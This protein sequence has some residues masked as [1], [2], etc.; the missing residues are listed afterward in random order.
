[1]TN[2]NRLAEQLSRDVSF[3]RDLGVVDYS[4][5]LGI[6]PLV[7]SDP[8]AN[9]TDKRNR[10][11]SRRNESDVDQLEQD[12]EEARRAK[13]N[14]YA[15]FASAIKRSSLGFVGAS[16]S[17]SS[18]TPY[19]SSIEATAADSAPSTAPP[20]AQLQYRNRR[21]VAADVVSSHSADPRDRSGRARINIADLAD[22]MDV[23]E[24]GTILV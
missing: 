8:S 12:E 22:Y 23:T 17:S 21:T 20:S 13:A 15:H 14:Y 9:T 6:Q 10:S 2:L 16:A 3:L 24:D 18:A 4:L 19:Y 11:R 5:L 1:M 7:Q